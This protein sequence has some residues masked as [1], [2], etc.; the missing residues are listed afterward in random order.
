VLVLGRGVVHRVDLAGRDLDVAGL[1]A[2]GLEHA[3]LGLLGL[4]P[5]LQA[6][7]LVVLLHELV[8][9]V[10][11]TRAR[12]LEVLGQLL[13]QLGQSLD[14]GGLLLLGLGRGLALGLLGREPLL[15]LLLF[16]GLLGGGRLVVLLGVVL[17]VSGDEQ[18]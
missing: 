12:G 18:R 14:R 1:D 7:A 13:R 5:A 8:L 10:G 9:G 16:V 15:E 11:D 2:A 4:V 17:L 6:F 3:H